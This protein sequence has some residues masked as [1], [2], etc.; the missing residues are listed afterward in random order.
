MQND[1]QTMPR[2]YDVGDNFIIT[3]DT[4]LV[5]EDMPL[6]LLIVP[7]GGEADTLLAGDEVVVAQFEVIS[8][9]SLDSVW[10]KVA[11]D[12][13]T[14]GWVHESTLLDS[15]VPDDPISQ[16]IYTFSH[17]HL[18]PTVALF[19]VALIAW[20]SRR[21][22]RKRFHVVHADDIASPFPMLLC[23]TLS[24]AAVLYSSI[25]NFCPSMWVHFYF[26]PTLNPFGQP[27]PLCTLLMMC[28]LMLI[29][30][31]ASLIDIRRD[32][33]AIEAILYSLSLFAVLA[34]LYTLFAVS[35]LY[36]VGYPLLLAYLVSAPVHFWRRHRARYVCGRCGA[37]LHDL[38][39]CPKCG[40]LNQ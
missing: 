17:S 9:D 32:L 11:R 20:L 18:V 39:E 37:Q 21:M 33:S 19:V 6:H 31:G 13:D 34:V 30:L 29:L 24:T 5:Q 16:S 4:L 40:T 14:Q 7:E 23:L 15:V 28:W 8:E 25:Q 36:Y 26:H 3:S 12:Q 22:M 10:V 38:G 2:E 27:W 1:G 35:T